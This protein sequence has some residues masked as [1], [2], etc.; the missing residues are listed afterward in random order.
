V[1]ESN[2]WTGIAE[3]GGWGRELEL[4]WGKYQH[5]QILFCFS[6]LPVKIRRSCFT[7]SS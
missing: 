3:Y 4:E 5:T 7:K 1:I 6:S 2:Q